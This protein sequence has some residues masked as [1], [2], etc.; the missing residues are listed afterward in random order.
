M[1]WAT[2]LWDRR[3]RMRARVCSQG[4]Q[5]LAD[6]HQNALTTQIDQR[7]EKSI[8]DDPTGNGVWDGTTAALNVATLLVPRARPSARR[9]MRRR[10]AGWAG[11]AASLDEAG[12]AVNASAKLDEAGEAV[13]AS[14][15]LDEAGEA[16]SAAADEASGAR[17]C[18][19]RTTVHRHFAK[20]PL[21]TIAPADRLI[22]RDATYPNLEYRCTLRESEGA[23]AAFVS[24]RSP[25][26][27][28]GRSHVG[29]SASQLH[30]SQRAEE[31]SHRQ[32]QRLA[33]PP[34]RNRP[35]RC[36]PRLRTSLRVSTPTACR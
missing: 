31:R 5:N 28:L 9:R 32:S 6:T 33:D 22:D 23:G 27:F 29:L 1:S 19:C 2:R 12:E 21:P 18:R 14:A 3:C 11:D 4:G 34:I 24:R 15:K 26:R 25:R 36:A 10:W 13:N 17:S 20:G 16:A 30:S 7:A 35:W 8:A